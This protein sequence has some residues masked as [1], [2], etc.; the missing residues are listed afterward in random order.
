MLKIHMKHRGFFSASTLNISCSF[1]LKLIC[2]ENSSIRSL[3][4]DIIFKS[5]SHQLFALDFKSLI[6]KLFGLF[7][8]IMDKSQVAWMRFK[9]IAS[10]CTDCKYEYVGNIGNIGAFSLDLCAGNSNFKILI[11]FKSI[12][13]HP[14][15]K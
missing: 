8:V 6:S 12:L 13:N 11:N 14:Y 2:I 5:N 4:L 3:R 15:S 7:E 9:L 1:Y 10:F